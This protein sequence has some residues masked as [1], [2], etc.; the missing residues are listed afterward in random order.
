MNA[1]LP[2][3]GLSGSGLQVHHGEPGRA[4][5]A[6]GVFGVDAVNVGPSVD[7]R[8]PQRRGDKCGRVVASASSECR[9]STA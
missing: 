8:S 3:A 9:R 5:V 2:E 6:S 7:D 1:R 4:P